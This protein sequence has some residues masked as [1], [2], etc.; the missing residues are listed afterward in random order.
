MEAGYVKLGFQREGAGEVGP[1][2]V[3]A[4]E[5]LRVRF[6][7]SIKAVQYPQI[8]LNRQA[9]R[10]LPRLVESSL[11]PTA[12][13]QRNRNK[14]IPRFRGGMAV[15][16]LDQPADQ[17]PATE[18][19]FQVFEANDGLE[20]LAFRLVG[21]TRPVEMPATLRTLFADEIRLARSKGSKRLAALVAERRHHRDRRRLQRIRP[22]KEKA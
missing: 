7:A 22:W 4:E 9:V 11:V 19:F 18:V 5:S 3:S 8:A 17:L 14:G 10:Q 16:R 15:K 6:S 12:E 20:N 1:A 13:M 21:R 2:L